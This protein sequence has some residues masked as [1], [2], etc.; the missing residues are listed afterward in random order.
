MIKLLKGGI[1]ILY[2]FR[3]GGCK[4]VLIY[5]SIITTDINFLQYLII[6]IQTIFIKNN[7]FFVITYIAI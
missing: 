2:L 6:F 5:F 7:F 4:K 3:F 1:N